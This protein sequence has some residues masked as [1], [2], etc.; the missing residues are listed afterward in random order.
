MIA[1]VELEKNILAFLEK[2]IDFPS[3]LFR[4]MK[5]HAIQ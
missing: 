5:E 1:N 4:K 3:D 2:A